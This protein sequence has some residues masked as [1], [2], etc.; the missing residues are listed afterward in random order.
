M[1]M[2]E[3]HLVDFQLVGS[4]KAIN[5]VALMVLHH[6][7]VDDD[8]I[9]GAFVPQYEGVFLKEVGCELLY[10]HSVINNSEWQIYHFFSL[11]KWLAEACA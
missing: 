10:F 5:L 8:C 2:G 3:Q 11:K 1:G 9:F 6:A 4:D 7:G